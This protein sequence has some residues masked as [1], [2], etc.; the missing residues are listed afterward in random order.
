MSIV[1]KIGKGL[2]KLSWALFKLAL[3]AVNE[4]LQ[5]A[6]ASKKKGFPRYTLYEASE[7]M[8]RGLVSPSDYHDSFQA[9]KH[10]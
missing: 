1:W 10:T 6:N 9:K 5:V 8:E 2:L 7:L 3:I 4:A